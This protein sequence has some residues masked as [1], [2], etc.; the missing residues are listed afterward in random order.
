MWRDST[1]SSLDCKHPREQCRTN[2]VPA[3]GG[4]LGRQIHRLHGTLLIERLRLERQR[5]GPASRRPLPRPALESVPRIFKIAEP[6]AQNQSGR[7]NAQ[8]CSNTIGGNCRL[9]S[10]PNATLTFFHLAETGP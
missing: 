1:H 4:S 6:D 3:H 7:A 5:E 10:L 2:E 9:P 8:A